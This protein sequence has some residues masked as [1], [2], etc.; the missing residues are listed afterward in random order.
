MGESSGYL[1]KLDRALV[2]LEALNCAVERWSN[3]EDVDI[4]AQLDPKTSEY[5]L[6][7]KDLASAGEGDERPR[8]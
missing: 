1:L 6:Q 2:H 5:V 8:R 3:S 7:A 4:A